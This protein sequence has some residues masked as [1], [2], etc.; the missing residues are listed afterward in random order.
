MTG[1]VNDA[2]SIPGAE[3]SQAPNPFGTP[4]GNVVIDIDLS[5]VSSGGPSIEEGTYLARVKSLQQT[6]A[7]SSGNPMV[8]AD[9]SVVAPGESYDGFDKLRVYMSLTAEALWKF[10]EFCEATGLIDEAGRVQFTP[11]QAIDRLL[12]VEVVHN[13][14]ERDGKLRTYA[15]P[16]AITPPP[17]GPGSTYSAPN[18]GIP[19]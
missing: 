2:P 1:L 12:T 15:N 4:D 14:V 5:D 17:D 18:E 7:K 3:G 8:V 9:L 19:S 6:R 13:E 16:G 10:K 11:D